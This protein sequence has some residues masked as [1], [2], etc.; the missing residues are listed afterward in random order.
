M[1]LSPS[2]LQG[3]PDHCEQEESAAGSLQTVE[4]RASRNAMAKER[5]AKQQ[6]LVKEG[7]DDSSY[8]GKEHWKEHII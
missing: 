5:S 3:K 8:Y 7:V 2:L 6:Q 1:F 4:F